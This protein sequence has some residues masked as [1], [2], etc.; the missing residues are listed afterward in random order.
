[1]WMFVKWEGT[2]M[3]VSGEAKV[4]KECCGTAFFRRM[5]LI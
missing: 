1:M 5:S 2:W 3:F 4:D